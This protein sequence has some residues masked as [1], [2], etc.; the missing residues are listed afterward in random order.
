MDHLF[1]QRNNLS[2]FSHMFMN[3]NLQLPNPD[4]T[5]SL[6]VTFGN[7]IKEIYGVKK[8]M[9]YLVSIFKACLVKL[10]EVRI[11]LCFPILYFPIFSKIIF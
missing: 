2:W 1:F 8:L 7:T 4:N 6:L 10:K 11:F 3:A 5:I 9:R